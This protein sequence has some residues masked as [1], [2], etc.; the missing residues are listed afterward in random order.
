MTQ[1]AAVRRDINIGTV[2]GFFG[3]SSD[4]IICLTSRPPKLPSRQRYGQTVKTI[5]TTVDYACYQSGSYSQDTLLIHPG[6]LDCGIHAADGLDNSFQ[7]DI[8][9]YFDG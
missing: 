2:L 9:Q 6:K 5:V 7:I 8:R 1:Q 4:G 3:I